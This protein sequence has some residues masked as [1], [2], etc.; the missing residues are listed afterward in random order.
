M[1]QVPEGRTILLVVEKNDLNLFL[2]L[3]SHGYLMNR[4]RIRILPL[5]EP[6]VPPH[7]FSQGVPRELAE[8]RG[9]KQNWVVRVRSIGDDKVW[10][11]GSYRIREVDVEGWDR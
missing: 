8:A 5:K 9:H 1:Q 6:T 10:L 2:C 3:A 7:T 4:I 11:V